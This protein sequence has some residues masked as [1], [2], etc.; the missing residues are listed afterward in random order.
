[1]KRNNKHPDLHEL[2]I[3]KCRQGNRESQFELYK[4][5]YKAMFNTCYRIVNNNQDAEDIMQESFLKAFQ[6]LGRYKGEASFGAWLK[7]IVVNQSI[8]FLRKRKIKFIRIED[9]IV[10]TIDEETEVLWEIDDNTTH[11]E[12]IKGIN[13]LPHGYKIIL[14]LYLLEGYDHDEISQILNI[15]PST[16]RSQF[17]RAKK[18]LLQNINESKNLK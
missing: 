18:R 14:S 8:D 10:N 17:N 6:N 11:K 1:M 2:L 16:S 15:T 12:I 5:Y 3:D 9:N 4:L 7:K 13:N